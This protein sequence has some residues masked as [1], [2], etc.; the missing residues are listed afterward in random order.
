MTTTGNGTC[1]AYT[2]NVIITFTDIPTVNAGLDQSICADIANVPLGGAVTIAAGGTWTTSG[3]GT[4]TPENT[5]LGGAYILSNGDTTAGTVTLT[6]TT[7][8]NG[9]CN[10]YN[11]Q[12]IITISP[13]PI[14]TA[15]TDQTLCG[16]VG[17]VA[18][19]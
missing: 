3:T 8:G 12:L 6:L 1:S 15:G 19:R 9:L 13:S 16:D 17:S 18:L 2:D 10:A 7:T 5:S 11:D 14:V 4:F